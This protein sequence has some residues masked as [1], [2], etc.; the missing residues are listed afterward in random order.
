MRCREITA[1]VFLLALCASG[2]IADRTEIPQA[3][4]KHGLKED[5]KRGFIGILFDLGSSD[6]EK[7]KS[8]SF[9]GDI[10]FDEGKAVLALKSWRELIERFPG[11]EEAILASE[12]INQIGQIVE[13]TTSETLRNTVARTYI[14]HGDWWSRGKEERLVIDTSWI[15]NDRVAIGWYD[16]V[17]KEF[18]D[19][20]AEVIALKKKF[21]TVYGWEEPGKYGKK[22]GVRGSRPVDDLIAVYEDLKT[23]SPTDPD[24]QR[25]R[26]MIAQS[27]WGKRDF[28]KTREWLQKIIDD[29]D[30][31]N[32]FYKDLAEWRM[33][34]VEY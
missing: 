22:Y 1:P 30:E 9:L 23:A 5:A 11:N 16:R 34:K 19:T 8:L 27:F 21:Y 6:D 7:A 32:G 3:Y 20:D 15:P 17:I 4:L 28:E 31:I 18:P 29:E 13:E 25:F 14:R 24:L 33:R 10:A 12:R 2:A 26:Y